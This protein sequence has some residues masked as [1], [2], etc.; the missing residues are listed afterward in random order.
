MLDS[1]P[2]SVLVSAILGFLSGLGIGG[3]S[4]L[5]LWLTLA[6]NTD[7]ITAR[8]INLLFFLPAAAIAFLFRYQQGAVEIRKIL[9]AIL[10]GTLA[11]ALFSWLGLQID[12]TLLKK[13]FGALL[14]LTGLRELFYK[15]KPSPPDVNQ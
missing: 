5:I 12:V 8:G 4:L 7:P 11:A 13:L 3:G 6:L 14:L 15:P 9:P 10:S 2:V 1:F